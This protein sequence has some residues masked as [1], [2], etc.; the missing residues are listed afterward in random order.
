MKRSSST[1]VAPRRQSGIALVVVLVLL[2]IMTLLGLASLR[3]TL[4]E[5]RMSA[6]LYD[7]SLSFQAVEAA[8]REV[9]ARLRDVNVRNQFPASGCDKG[10]CARP[11]PTATGYKDRA[12]DPAFAGWHPATQVDALTATPAY[13]VENMGEAA[14]WFECKKLIPVDPGC[15]SPRYRVTA[16][17]SAA[18]R[19]EV[20]IQT[21]Y[22]AP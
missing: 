19:A 22:A 17:S 1:F 20:V 18:D 10:L 9:E 16:R 5:E 6:N 12:T 15:L 21:S 8:L 2:L 13:F 14:N 11:D 4:L 3:G 7:R